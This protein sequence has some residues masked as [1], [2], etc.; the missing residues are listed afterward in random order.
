MDTVRFGRP[1]SGFGYNGHY[2]SRSMGVEWLPPTWDPQFSRKPLTRQFRDV[3]EPG[4][5][6]L[7]AD[8]AQVKLASLSPPKL[9]FEENWILD[10]PSQNYPSIHFRHLDVANAVFL[11]GHAETKSFATHVEIPGDNWLSSE[12]AALMEKRTTRFPLQ[13]QPA[14]ARET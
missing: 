13:R 4:R 1:A 14:I 10:P 6:V 7:F 8:C 3:R 11:D 9:S 5:T 12:Q 2:L